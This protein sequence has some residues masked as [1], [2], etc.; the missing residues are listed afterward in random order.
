MPNIKLL[1]LLIL[2]IVFVTQKSILSTNAASITNSVMEF[3]EQE[4]PLYSNSKEVFGIKDLIHLS[5]KMSERAICKEEDDAHPR[6]RQMG[7][8]LC[9]MLDAHK[10][11]EKEAFD[12]TQAIIDI[13]HI[14]HTL[15]ANSYLKDDVKVSAHAA[16]TEVYIRHSNGHNTEE[17][18]KERKRFLEVVG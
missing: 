13:I 18:Y 2:Q 6:Q 7:E 11:G 1:N 8:M 5:T 10:D 15:I 9:A 16:I 17:I 14:A 4:L 12:M 3:L